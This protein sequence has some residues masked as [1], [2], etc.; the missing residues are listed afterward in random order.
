MDKTALI[1]ED[2]KTQAQIIAR[3]IEAQGWT[4][5]HCE[6]VRAAS[7]TLTQM[8]VHVMFLDVF[9]GSYNALLHVERFRKSAP[10]TP[11]AV[12]TAGNSREAIEETLKSA[13]R[14]GADFVL[15]KPFTETL[16]RSVLETVGLDVEAG[17][18]RKHVLVIDDSQT[19]RSIATGALRDAGYRISEAGTMEEA[20]SNVD[21]AHIDLV[22]CDVFMPGMGGLKGMRTIKST[23]P[24]VNIIS[25]SA[26][27]ESKVSHQDA[28]NATRRFGVE[29]QLAKPFAPSDL[30]ELTQM[31]LGRAA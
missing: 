22:L 7:E 17:A 24:A 18:R 6:D 29:A 20:F 23:W 9:V 5:I 28:L 25:M 14:S 13:R 12:M 16:V 11:I 27:M 4:V 10:Q 31:L 30:I 19:V 1:L 26:G 3:M 8:R 15:R 21:I 2:S